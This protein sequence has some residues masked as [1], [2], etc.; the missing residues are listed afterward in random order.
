M[1]FWQKIFL[2]TLVIFILAFDVG[3]YVLTTYSYNFNRKR[4]TE[5]S[6]R[7]QSVILVSVASRIANVETIYVDAPHNKDRLIAILQPL[8][9]YYQ[10]QGVLLALFDGE[11]EVY[12]TIPE[13]DKELLHLESVQDKNAVDGRLGDKRHVFVASQIPDYPHLTLVYARDISQIDDFRKNVSQVFTATNVAVVALMGVG[14][15]LLLRRM[16]RPIDKLNQ[17]TAEIAGGAYDKRVAMNRRDELG[18]LGENFN[19]MADSVEEHMGQLTKAAEAKQQF[20]D[21][22]THE[23]KTPMTTI[24]GYAEYLQN[25]KS[26]EEERQIAAGHLQDAALRLKNLS[27]KLLEL[28]Y[29][30]GEKIALRKVNMAELFGALKD[31]MG[32]ILAERQIALDAQTEISEIDG[33]ETLLLSML[34]NL[35]ENGAKASQ[36]QS[37]ITVRAYEDGYPVIEVRDRGH[38]MEQEETQKITDPFYRVD[39]S[40]SRKFGGV[41]LGLSIVS[42]IAALHGAR[43]EIESKPGGGTR[44]KICFI[45]P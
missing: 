44:V 3:A 19:R 18:N 6:I 2:G 42:Q 28:A 22:L 37:G 24:L 23:M 40:R 13:L 32:P 30:R 12:A 5:N 26:T 43:L 1:K 17:A 41:G 16:T 33:D 38:G 31:M 45:T 11:A 29:L 8:T 7:E 15:Y 9:D 35:V 14:I 10:P 27:D 4:E 20:I 39:K 21:D 34:T 36:P 25:A